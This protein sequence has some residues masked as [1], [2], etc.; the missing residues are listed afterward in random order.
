MSN[1]E[2]LQP[3]PSIPHPST[4]RVRRR[5]AS[6]KRGELLQYRA[7]STTPDT[8]ARGTRERSVVISYGGRNFF[9]TPE[10]AECFLAKA[11]RV[12]ESNGSELV[13]LLHRGGLDLLL[14]ADNIPF[15][16]GTVFEHRAKVA[17]ERRD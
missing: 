5:T 6:P 9:A 11:R 8:T 13:A 4:P 15:S 16:V 7:R 14:I 1:Q 10:M 17:H 12:V 2:A 3:R